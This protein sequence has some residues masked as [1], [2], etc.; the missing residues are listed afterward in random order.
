MMKVKNIRLPD[1]KI[2]SNLKTHSKLLPYFD[3][4]LKRRQI[5]ASH[6][7]QVFIFLYCQLFQVVI[8]SLNIGTQ[9]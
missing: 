2:S 3:V 4:I 9:L 5:L 1:A 7:K 8:T 6:V